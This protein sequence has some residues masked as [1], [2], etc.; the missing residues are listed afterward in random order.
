MA[1][2]NATIT[3]TEL[4][5]R[6][7]RRIGVKRPT[8]TERAQAVALLNDLCKEIDT[9]GRWLWAIDNSPSSLT[10]VAAQASYA[11]GSGASLIPLYG[12]ELERMELVIGSEPYTPLEILTKDG[13]LSS[14]LRG[15]SGQPLEAYF[16]KKPDSSDSLLWLAPTPETAYTAK[17]YWRRR[18]YDFDN[19]SDN[20]DL[21][22]DNALRL[23]K[24]LAL[25]LSPEYGIPLQERTLLKAESN[26]AMDMMRVSNAETATPTRRVR[27]KGQF[28]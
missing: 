14:P 27:V 8:N 17:C 5:D 3:R 21:P 25:E 6:A 20:P 26:E 19:A 9:E 16:E 7:L 12:M 15:T 1:D 2:S 24:R 11:A 18:L 4:V 23:A 13:W 10:L 28:Y 22:Q